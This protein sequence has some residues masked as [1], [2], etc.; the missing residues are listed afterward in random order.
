MFSFDFSLPQFFHEWLLTYLIFPSLLYI[1]KHK[2]THS[3]LGLLEVDYLLSC[4]RELFL[5]IIGRQTFDICCTNAITLVET[6][7]LFSTT[8]QTSSPCAS[9]CAC[10][11]IF[12]KNII[13]TSEQMRLIV[14]ITVSKNRICEDIFLDLRNKL[15]I[16]CFD[17][18][19]KFRF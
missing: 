5:I 8:S 2:R 16:T 11:R 10:M 18:K 15:F 7:K 3:W 9:W 17:V 13:F 14:T 4:H 1:E 6:N 12:Q 19:C